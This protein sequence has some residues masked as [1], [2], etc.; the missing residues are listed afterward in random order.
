MIVTDRV[1]LSAGALGT[2]TGAE[3]C[4]SEK[5]VFGAATTGDAAA[6]AEAGTN[7]AALAA[8]SGSGLLC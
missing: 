6:D 4:S 3:R 1:E 7:S 2:K 8:K 5:F